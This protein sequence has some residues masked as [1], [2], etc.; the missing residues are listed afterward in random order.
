[1]ASRFASLRE[2]PSPS[3]DRKGAG[4]KNPTTAIDAQSGPSIPTTTSRPGYAGAR[5]L[6][7]V[8]VAR[9]ASQSPLA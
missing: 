1:M 2:A 7:G 3:R 5:K 8:L 6:R 9:D 4:G